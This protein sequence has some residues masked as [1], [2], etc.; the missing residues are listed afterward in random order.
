M[1]I[2]GN[3][4]NFFANR[5]WKIWHK[6]ALMCLAFSI[7]IGALLYNLIKQQN[8]EI[9]FARKELVGTEYLRPLRVL[10]DHVN[11]HRVLAHR[12]LS[13]E[14]VSSA[15]LARLPG[16]IEQDLE[17]LAAV[18]AKHGKTLSQP[19]RRSDEKVAG[20]KEKWRTLKANLATLTPAA[21]DTQ[22]GA[23]VAQLRDLVS[24]AGDLSNLILDPDLDS[25]YVM[26]SVLLKLPDAQGLLM[27]LIDFGEDALKKKTL[28]SD[29]RTDFVVKMSLVRNNAD[30][31]TS[32]LAGLPAAFKA[33]STADARL[34]TNLDPDLKATVASAT[35]Y[36]DLI[37]KKALGAGA[38]TL[39]EAELRA[40]GMKALEANFVLWDKAADN[41]D[42]LLKTR[43]AGFQQNKLVALLG[44]AAA[45]AAALVLVFFIVR[46]FTK[47]IN[48]I[49][50]LF[51]QIGIGNFQ[52]RARVV[53]S[54]ELGEVAQVLNN[55]LLPLV[56]SREEKD[57]IQGS[58]QKLLEEISGVAEGDL[59]RDAEVT[60]DVTGAIA[61][62]F[63]Y[64]IDQLRQIIGNVQGATLQVSTSASQVHA[65]AET[66]VQGSAVQAEQIANTTKAVDEMATSIRQVSENAVMS[67]TVAEQAKSNAQQGAGAV[68]NTIQ[69]MGRIRDKMQETA[70]RIK[71]LGESSQQIGEIVQLIDDIADR[72]SIL[73]LNASIQAAMA[74]EAGRGFAV[75]A[76][77][78]ERLAERSTNSTKKIA[79]L[80]KTIQSETNEAITSMEEC[81]HEV[82]EGS[83]LAN[84]AGKALGEIESVSNK[85]AEL[86]QSISLAARQQARASE[87]IAKSM[88]DISSVTQQTASGTRQASDAVNQLASLADELRGSVSTFRLPG[89]NGHG[90]GAALMSNGH[91]NGHTNGNGNGHT[92]RFAEM[93]LAR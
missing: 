77:E 35:G 6:L 43:I 65:T 31:L 37:Q 29:D 46:S 88:T 23:I 47:Q 76:E 81:T 40:E 36:L 67:A 24:Q 5:Q 48:A 75:V 55:Y 15:E 66:L 8:K 27:D 52:A 16:V 79:S 30:A 39:S 11:Q 74:G 4:R 20:V 57:A 26:D 18:D 70:K 13:G 84:D 10:L 59:T 17:A 80:I 41:L 21:S 90:D 72:T 45:L 54:D 69:G 82:V 68:Q 3:L 53:S 44:S 78:V 60:A 22:H 62:S 93:D 1:S 92:R 85:L 61:D 49:T 2:G 51:H 12:Y 38:A 87:G 73:A 9:D 86:I 91:S 56:Q 58:I 19:D 89:S 34:K 7:P 42:H 83:G 64:M 32:P 71:R 28:S 63:N 14:N 50:E 25:Y 33:D